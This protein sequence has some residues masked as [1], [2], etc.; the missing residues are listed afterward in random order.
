MELGGPATLEV[1]SRYGEAIVM[2]GCVIFWLGK[3]AEHAYRSI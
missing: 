1:R 3:I 2:L